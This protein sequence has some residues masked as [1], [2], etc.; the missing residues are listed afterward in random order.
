[1]ERAKQQRE[2]LLQLIR[3]RVLLRSLL[4]KRD[5]KHLLFQM[6]LVEDIQC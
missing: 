5:M 2:Y 3:R 6:T 1:M 4:M